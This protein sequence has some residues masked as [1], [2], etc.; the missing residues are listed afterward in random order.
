MRQA[1]NNN[2]CRDIFIFKICFQLLITCQN[3]T[4]S[5]ILY[6]YNFGYLV[7]CCFVVYYCRLFCILIKFDASSFL[8]LFLVIIYNAGYILKNKLSK[9]DTLFNYFSVFT[10]Y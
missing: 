10:T 3:T 4:L 1:G 8:L 2:H 6:W 5:N 9:K 7:S